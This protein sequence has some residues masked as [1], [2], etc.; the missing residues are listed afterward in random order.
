MLRTKSGSSKSAASK[1]GTGVSLSFLPSLEARKEG[2]K[3]IL[4]PGQ[5]INIMA[6]GMMIQLSRIQIHY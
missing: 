4:H 1:S 2:R 3:E 6:D 5:A